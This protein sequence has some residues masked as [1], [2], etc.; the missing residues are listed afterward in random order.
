MDFKFYLRVKLPRGPRL[1][2]DRWRRLAPPPVRLTQ[3]L[4]KFDFDTFR[5]LEKKKKNKK[6]MSW[7]LNEQEK[8]VFNLPFSTMVVGPSGCGKTALVSRILL[9]SQQLFDK[10][11]DRIVFCYSVWQPAYEIFKFLPTNVEFVLGL[12]ESLEFSPLKTNVLVI[13]DLFAS[14][15]D[16]INIQ[17]L[18]AVESH[19][20][21]ISVFLIAHN[22]FTKGHFSR[23]LSLN[24][25][26]LII[27][28]N[29][30]DSIQ[31][32]V[33]ARQIFPNKSKAFMEIFDDATKDVPH[34]YI[35]LDFKQ[36]TRSRMRIQSR[37]V[38]ND[39]NDQHHRII[40]TINE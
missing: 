3:A 20:K 16:S 31:V 8:F 33:L 13:D 6:K 32:G 25:S 10:R 4:N 37:I 28:R 12:S 5:S 15:K 26:N 21:N 24:S 17:N 7:F 40:Y 9:N 18:F 30:R 2:A 34:G 23:D 19:H 14:A 11:V 22:I 36:S 27:F 1:P 39:N 38:G 35:F 29:P